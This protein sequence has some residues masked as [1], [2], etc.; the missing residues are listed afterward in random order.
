MTD[1]H[2][3]HLESKLQIKLPAAFRRFMLDHGEELARARKLLRDEVV[4]ETDPKRIVK[5]NQ[6]LRKYGYETGDDATPTP[7]PREYLA[8]SD[9]GA[10]DHDCLRATDKSAPVFRFDGESGTFARQFK[11]PDDYLAKLRRRVTK[12]QKGSAGRGDPALRDALTLIGDTSAFSVIVPAAGQP[13]TPATLRAAGVDVPGLKA[14]LATLLEV[15]TGVRR[16]RWKIATGKGEYPTQM[17]A[18]YSTTA[19]P[20]KPLALSVLSM[21][22]GDLFLSLH[23]SDDRMTVKKL[24]LDWRAFAQALGDL[25][26]AV[27]GQPV[28]LT[29]GTPSGKFEDGF[30]R[31]KCKYRVARA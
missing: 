27:S 7:W 2:L 6:D 8:L 19:K 23:S 17:N 20:P 28:Q 11:T 10:G 9:N 16:E 31:F 18:A 4:W 3:A 25:Y 26:A 22:E 15:V 1:A 13:A 21:S 30:G 24:P 14:G 29:M 12:A 5:L